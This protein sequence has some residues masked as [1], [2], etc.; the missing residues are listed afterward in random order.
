M[1]K[2]NVSLENLLDQL[3]EEKINL[4]VDGSALR[5]GWA[6]E[7]PPACG[8]GSGSGGSGSGSGKSHKTKKAKK[9]HSGKSGNSGCFCTCG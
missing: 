4:L 5:A 7:P 9:A 3:S 1:E 6:T 2:S 8:S